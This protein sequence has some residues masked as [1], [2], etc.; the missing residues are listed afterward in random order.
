MKSMKTLE[1]QRCLH[2]GDVQPGFR[3]RTCLFAVRALHRPTYVY[4]QC[5]RHCI[6]HCKIAAF[7]DSERFFCIAIVRFA[8]MP[9]TVVSLERVC[10]VLHES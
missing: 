3:S 7:L 6:A 4:W 9:E 5:T 2:Q 10:I 1:G 8:S